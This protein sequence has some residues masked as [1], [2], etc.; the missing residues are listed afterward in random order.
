MT[1]D[2]EIFY[3]DNCHGS[4]KATCSSTVPKDWIKQKKRKDS[5]EIANEYTRVA[6]E[7][8]IEEQK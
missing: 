3:E 8:K 1:K 6:T 7:S 5:R 4:Y 2:D